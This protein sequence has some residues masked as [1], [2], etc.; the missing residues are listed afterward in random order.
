MSS[1]TERDNY[2]M[3]KIFTG[4]LTPE[5]RKK[6][7]ECKAEAQERKEKIKQI[8]ENKKAALV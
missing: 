6:R 4:E 2:K 8:Y 7:E 1:V 3:P 5:I